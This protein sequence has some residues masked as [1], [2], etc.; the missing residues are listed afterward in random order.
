MDHGQRRRRVDQ[1]EA[2]LRIDHQAREG[3][4]DQT[5]ARM[6]N[7]I[8]AGAS[9]AQLPEA[10]NP[11]VAAQ[12]IDENASANVA[13]RDDVCRRRNWLRRACTRKQSWISVAAAAAANM[14]RP[15]TKPAETASSIN[16]A[17]IGANI[18]AIMPMTAST[19]AHRMR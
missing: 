17:T 16:T 2:V 1:S 13:R 19:L 15:Q 11:V 5:P 10:A 8:A 18:S 9:A 12:A 7:A 4:I 14:P 6:A 3:L